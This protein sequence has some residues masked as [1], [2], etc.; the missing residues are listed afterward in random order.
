MSPFG[1]SACAPVW[2]RI[3]PG[4]FLRDGDR[5]SRTQAAFRVAHGLPQISILAVGT[6]EPAHLGELTGALA[7]EVDEQAVREYRDLIRTRT[8]GQPA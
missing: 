8:R 1:G 3:N 6:D 2:D 7:S 4:V 5:L